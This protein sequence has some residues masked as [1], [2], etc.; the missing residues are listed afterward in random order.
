MARQALSGYDNTKLLKCRQ[1]N[2]KYAYHKE[3]VYAAYETQKSVIAQMQVG[4]P[5][6]NF[7]LVRIYLQFATLSLS[8]LPS[9][10]NLTA[11]YVFIQRKT[12]ILFFGRVAEH[13]YIY[14]SFV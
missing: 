3:E 14:I 11:I 10:F 5:F 6:C 7:S 13:L 8:L 1:K 12:M 2:H 9:I 4:S